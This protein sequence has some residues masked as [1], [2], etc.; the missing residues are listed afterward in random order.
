MTEKFEQHKWIFEPDGSLLDIYVQETKLDDWLNLI[1][2]LNEN[3]KIK[4][5]P[6]S[7]NEPQDKINKVYVTSFLLDTTGELECRTVSVFS[8]N[9]IFNCHFFLQDEIELD[10]DPKEF[11]GQKDFETLIAFMTAISKT[12]NKEIILTAEG[13]PTIP[14]ITLES[15]SGLLKISTQDEVNEE[16]K[17]SFTLTGRLRGIY[18]FSLMQLLPKLKNLKFRN[19]LTNHVMGLMGATKPHKA[20]KK[21]TSAK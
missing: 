13:C 10:A 14:L 12:L 19:W 9:L 3:Y 4:Y 11:K 21:K 1:D 17:K 8:D 5:G 16:H 15:S 20:T 2:F 18:I 7:D 6:A